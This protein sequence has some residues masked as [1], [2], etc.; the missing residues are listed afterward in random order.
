MTAIV[1]VDG[2]IAGLRALE[3]EIRGGV[4]RVLAKTANEAVTRARAKTTIRSIAE[5]IFPKLGSGYYSVIIRASDFKAAFFENGTGLYGPRGAK[6][7]I[8]ARRAPL[9]RFQI[10]GRWISTRSVMHPGVHAQHFMAF[11]EDEMRPWFLLE[12]QGM[13]DAAAA[14]HTG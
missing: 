13:V 8:V 4:A 5:S 2:A 3:Q 12:M 9:L 14:K 6:Y 1:R 11:T 10:N 7:S